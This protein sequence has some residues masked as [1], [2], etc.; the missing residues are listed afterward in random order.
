MSDSCA[1]GDQQVIVFSF[2]KSEVE[3]LSAQMVSMDLNSEEEK[4]LAESVF[5]N[6]MECLGE[7]DRKLPQVDAASRL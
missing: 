2:S 5:R 4:A 7:E 3:A 1:V 6:A